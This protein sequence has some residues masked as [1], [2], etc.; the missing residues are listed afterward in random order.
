MKERNLITS[1]KIPPGLIKM[2]D[3]DIKQNNDF[4]NRSEWIISAIRFYESERIRIIKERKLLEIEEDDFIKTSSTS[5]PS[6]DV[7][8]GE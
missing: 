1:I 3:D 6:G 7:T 2:I 4:R 5:V 8:D